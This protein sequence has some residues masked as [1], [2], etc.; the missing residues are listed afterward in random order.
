MKI[1]ISFL[2]LTACSLSS[3]AQNIELDWANDFVAKAQKAKPAIDVSDA[4]LMIVVSSVPN[5]VDKSKLQLKINGGAQNIPPD[6]TPLAEGQVAFNGG[7]ALITAFQNG[8]VKISLSS[9]GAEVGFVTFTDNPNNQQTPPQGG[10]GSTEKATP[11]DFEN[12]VKS[13]YGKKIKS[14]T[15][16]YDRKLNQAREKNIIHVFLDENGN[17]YY[18]SLPT[19]AREDNLFVFHL[20]YET[21]ANK[22][23]KLDVEGEYDPVFEVYGAASQPQDVTVPNSTGQPKKVSIT[24]QTFGAVGPFTGS[25]SVKITRM[26]AS[27]ALLDKTIKCAKLHHITLNAGLY[28]T[29]LRYPDNIEIYQKPNGDSTLV[30]DDPTS[31]GFITVMLTFY[32]KARNILYPSNDW[33]EKIGFSIGTSI[34]KKLAENFFGG[35][36]YDVARGLALT[37]GAHYGRRNFVI[38]DRN[39]KFGEDKF[40]GTLDGRIKKRWDVSWYIGVNI[41]FRLLSYIFNP[42]QT[43]P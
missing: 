10:T 8:T 21:A 7:A 41:D 23:F 5:N 4:D 22:K 36:S 31:R 28:G 19:T 17:F 2:L 40:S 39:F 37:G 38:D 43:Q 30:A 35:I 1:L 9:N 11:Q 13:K 3:F 26:G 16:Q 25:F 27:A 42:Q 34:S 12:A 29:A 32:P 15:I 24:E 20:F 18:S 14:G 6:P 33:R